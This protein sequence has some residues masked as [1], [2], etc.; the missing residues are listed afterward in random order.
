MGCLQSREQEVSIPAQGGQESSPAQAKTTSQS[1]L[2]AQGES[3]TQETS[4]ES[5]GSQKKPACNDNYDHLENFPVRDDEEDVT[6]RGEGSTNN[7]TGDARDVSDNGGNGDC[8]HTGGHDT[9]ESSG[10]GCVAGDS[11]GGGDSGGDDGD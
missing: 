8:G 7:D 4:T 2:I 9:G 1:D 10:D 6:G 11:G 3:N 5:P